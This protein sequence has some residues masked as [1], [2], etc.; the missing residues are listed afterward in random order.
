MSAIKTA[1]NVAKGTAEA[2]KG[3]SKI[4]GSG[5]RSM[6]GM[7]VGWNVITGEG[8]IGAAK[9]GV[10][11]DE[12]AATLEK[13]GALGLASDMIFG[14]GADNKSLV[15]NVSNSMIG[16]K[17]TEQAG[18]FIRDIPENVSEAYNRARGSVQNAYNNYHEG[19]V[20]QFEN[21][22]QQG[23]MPGYAP[24]YPQNAMSGTP[25]VFSGM[26][27]MV[28]GMTGGKMN[29]WDMA[30]MMFA[31]YMMF[32]SKFGLLGKIGGMLAGH[33]AY[34]GMQ[35]RN[36]Q[37]MM[38]TQRVQQQ[39]PVQVQQP[40]IPVSPMPQVEEVSQAPVVSRHR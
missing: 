17:H 22:Y 21:P 36:S 3:G 31:A 16:T 14:N 34:Q 18:Q 1:L 26:D 5:A 33:N 13:H 35:Q 10:L 2:A 25:G 20:Q 19:Q 11:G 27:Q 38:Q 40:Y 7:Y 37:N 30:Q 28:G 4:I 15:E 23:D 9:K 8:F 32:T 39:M 6:I 12:A 29:T 24:T